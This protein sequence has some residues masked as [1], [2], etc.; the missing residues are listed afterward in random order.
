[1]E[2]IGFT[3]F[4]TIWNGKTINKFNGFIALVTIGC[5]T[6]VKSNAFLASGSGWA[7]AGYCGLKGRLLDLLRTT[8][9]QN[10]TGAWTPNSD[11]CSL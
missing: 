7:R 4:Q 11:F 9:L 3:A 1:M 6:A 2:Q 5:E 8:Q 10:D